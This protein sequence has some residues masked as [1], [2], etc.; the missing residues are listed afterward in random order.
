MVARCPFQSCLDEPERG[1]GVGSVTAV[2]VAG[3][4]DVAGAGWFVDSG[5]QVPQGG[6]GPGAV[7]GADLGC[8]LAAGDIAHRVRKS[9][10]TGARTAGFTSC[11][12]PSRV[13]SSPCGIARLSVLAVSAMNGRAAGACL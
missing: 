2:G 5:G 9:T 12:W 7:A 1:E 3:G 8:V 4:G 13:R 11:V 6:H 10:R